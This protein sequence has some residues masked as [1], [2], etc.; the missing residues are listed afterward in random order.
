M[1]IAIVPAR[2]GSKRIPRKNVR[3]FCGKPMIAWTLDA[4][5]TSGCFDRILVSTDD[6]E[7]AEIARQW[8]ADTPFRRPA[9]L[10]DDHTP[11][12]PVIAHALEWLTSHAE[13]PVQAVCCAYATAPLMQPGDLIQAG[14]LLEAD[15]ALDYVFTATSF[16]FPVQR[17]LVRDGAGVKALFTDSIQRRSQDLEDAF[18][19]AGQFYWGTA[20]AFRQGRP[21]F[22][23]CSK[24]LLIPRHRVQDIDTPEDWAQAELMSRASRLTP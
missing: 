7:V 16:A 1:K 13:V 9:Q 11:T 23:P 19:D 10:A 8:G 4:L 22:G 20:E 17:A 24:P 18:H 2:G 15:P 21:I 14:R 5:S 3:L 6:D 12:L